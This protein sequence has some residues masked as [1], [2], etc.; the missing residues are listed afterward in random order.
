[1]HRAS[2]QKRVYPYQQARELVN[3]VFHFMIDDLPEDDIIGWLAEHRPEQAAAIMKQWREMSISDQN[4]DIDELK[5][6]CGSIKL[7]LRRGLQIWSARDLRTDV[8][9][10]LF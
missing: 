3:G 5:Q 7:E 8:Q 4:G 2:A 9:D 6:A 10:G 1:M